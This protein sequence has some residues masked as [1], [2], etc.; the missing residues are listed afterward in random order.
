MLRTFV[1]TLNLKQL[2]SLLSAE[3]L[4]AEI[5]MASLFFHLHKNVDVYSY[6]DQMVPCISNFL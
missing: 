4:P 3:N 2:L 1:A 5:V 6:N